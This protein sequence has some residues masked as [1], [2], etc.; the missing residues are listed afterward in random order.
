[1]SRTFPTDALDGCLSVNGQDTTVR[2]L[3]STYQQ[4]CTNPATAPTPDA[5]IND[6]HIHAP[7]R[8]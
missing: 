6:G 2:G 7:W 3:A 1:M 4:K 8:T 5:M